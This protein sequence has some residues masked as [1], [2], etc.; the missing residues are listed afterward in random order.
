MSMLAHA[1]AYAGR[2]RPVFP[3][4]KHKR[5]LTEHGFKDA[6]TAE[7]TIREW[8][9][10]WPQAGIATPMGGGL[11]VLDADD[12]AALAALEAEHG[13]LPPTVEV[14]TPRPGR[15]IYLGGDGIT[16]SAGALPDGIDVR[17]IG[18]YVVL[19]PSPGYEWRTAPD[20]IPIAPA[21]PWLLALLRSTA[22]GTGRGDRQVRH[23][24]VR[25]GDRHPYLTDFAVRL[26]RGGITDADAIEA[27]LRCEFARTC[28]PV[29]AWR[30]A[31]FRQLAAWAAS[32]DIADRER[33]RMTTET[34]SVAR[35]PDRWWAS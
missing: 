4:G 17:G 29:P 16:N 22:N 9:A 27:H 15:H 35:P 12:E 20:E 33:R 18:G 25:A 28:V 11:F 5:P 19:P 13:Q 31:E 23:D 3:V 7:A 14:I 10:Q 2:R 1:L 24:P 6:T 30:P 8:W 32:T 26:L 21:P 34:T